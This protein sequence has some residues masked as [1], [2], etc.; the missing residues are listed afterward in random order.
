MDHI[1]QS[2]SKLSKDDTARLVLDYQGKFDSVLKTVKDDICKMKT[3]FKTLESEFHVSKT[4]TDNLTK[5]IKTSERKCYENEQYTRRECLEISGILGNIDDNALEETVLGLL[6]KY[7]ALVDPSNV[8]D[9]HRL[10]S[11]NNAPQ[12]V[13]IK[14]SKQKDMYRVLKAKPSLKN[15]NLNGT[16]TPPGTPIFV[17]QSLCSWSK[18]K[19]LWLNKVVES[20]WVPKGLCRMSLLDYSLQ[21]RL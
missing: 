15:V 5:Y 3:K 7:H 13:I 1:E 14:L 18:C 8:E 17:N 21:S 2:L 4:V 11:T 12:K 19:R 6:S 10:K 16:G 20:F 9:C